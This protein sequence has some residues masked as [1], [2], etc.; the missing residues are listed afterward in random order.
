ML[1]DMN[2]GFTRQR[3]GATYAPDLDLGNFGVNTLHIPGTNSDTY[4]AQGTPAFIFTTG[5]WNSMGNSDTGN[6]F[7][8]RDNQ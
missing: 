8:F 6:P 2:L 3:L 5:G 7:L 1:V 4:L